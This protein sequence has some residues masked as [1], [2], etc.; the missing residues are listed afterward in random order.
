MRF[1]FK[2]LPDLLNHFRDEQVCID[3]LVQQRWGGKPV[4]VHCGNVE[5]IYKIENGKRFKCS[6]CKMK[7]S[8]KVGTVFAESALPLSTWYAAIYVATA[9]KKGISSCQLARD[10]GITQKS[11]WFVL[12]RV[13]EMFRI[14]TP[15]LLTGEIE[16]DETFVGGKEKNK[17]G[18]MKNHRVAS[19][20]YAAPA[21]RNNDKF[22]V[23][24]MLQRDGS[25]RVHK[26]DNTK[27]RTLIPL[28]VKNVVPQ[29]FIYSDEHTG[30]SQLH[31]VGYK[32]KSV[33][34]KDGE[35][36]L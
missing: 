10:L 34:H 15:T 16:I 13:R 6:A 3:Y 32:H 33:K 14:K 8:A 35:Y 1:N 4:C 11:A 27:G 9:H 20:I 21:Q 36:V 31:K 29:A 17:H 5:N 18:Y 26:V 2:S 7:F 25:I 24:G 19:A 30:Y 22:P 23:F 28:I 12:H